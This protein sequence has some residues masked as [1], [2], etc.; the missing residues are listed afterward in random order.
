MCI[1]VPVKIAVCEWRPP[2]RGAGDADKSLVAIDQL[3]SPAVS[4]CCAVK[5]GELLSNGFFRVSLHPTPL[6]INNKYFCVWIVQQPF[7]IALDWWVARVYACALLSLFVSFLMFSF[8][9]FFIFVFLLSLCLLGFLLFFLL[10]RP[11]FFLSFCF[12]SFFLIFLCF[13]FSYS[14]IHS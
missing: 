11:P 10:Y 13:F 1:A 7:S 14:I 2:A 5:A 6:Q 8:F 3:L 9:P 12:M 4:S